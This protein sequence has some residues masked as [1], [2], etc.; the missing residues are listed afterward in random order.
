[1]RVICLTAGLVLILAL[2][3]VQAVQ[4]GSPKPPEPEAKNA[5]GLLEVKSVTWLSVNEKLVGFNG[6][7]PY[8]ISI[9]Q[10]IP[11]AAAARTQ[12]VGVLK[13]RKLLGQ[14]VFAWHGT[15]PPKRIDVLVGDEVPVPLAQAVIAAYVPQATLPV[16]VASATRDDG[17][18]LK[19]R[20]MVGSLLTC[21]DTPVTA[22][23][24]RRLLAPGLTREQLTGLLPSFQE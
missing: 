18:Y 20:V 11:G 24:V 21:G 12:L 9:N 19:R 15:A 6:G 5:D 23:Q 4:P 8:A 13:E 10:Q 16:Y 22:E 14:A 2:L 3:P 7:R 1:M 17:F